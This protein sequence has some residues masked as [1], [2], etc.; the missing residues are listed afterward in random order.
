MSTYDNFTGSHFYIMS[1]YDVFT[2]RNFER[3][4]IMSDFDMI[5]KKCKNVESIFEILTKNNTFMC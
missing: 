1:T 5:E 4:S 2:R 3:F